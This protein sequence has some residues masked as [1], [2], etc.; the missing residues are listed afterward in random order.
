MTGASGALYFVRTTRALLAGGHRVDLV[1]SRHGLY[2][3]KEETAY[4]RFEGSIEEWFRSELG[5]GMSGALFEHGHRDQTAPIASGSD[6]ADGMIV[7]PCT[8]KTLAGIAQG[9]ATNLI[10]RA[11]DVML[12]ERRRLVLVVREAPYNLIHLRNM[13]QVAEAGGSI[14]PASPAFYARPETFDDLGDFIAQRALGLVG[15][16]VD[17]FRRWGR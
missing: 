6:P 11:A 3:L 15:I 5:S 7:V 17:L 4:G 10:E 9:Y 1:V 2:T 16:D 12:K 14:L 13:Q 8:V